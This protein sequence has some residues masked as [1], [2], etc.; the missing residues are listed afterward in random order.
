M[1]NIYLLI[2][3][4]ALSYADVNAQ[5]NRRKR[6]TVLYQHEI[7]GN[8]GFS[9][10]QADFEPN[11][12]ANGLI[13]I[14][15]L[16]IN[17][18]HSVHLLPRRYDSSIFV[19]RLILKSNFGYSYGSFNN[20]G[21][22]TGKELL[23]TTNTAGEKD[24]S[25]TPNN[26]L[27]ARLTSKTSIITFGTQLEFYFRDIT[28]YLHRFNKYRQRNK[29]NPYIALGFGANYVNSTPS[30]DQEALTNNAGSSSAKSGGFPDNYILG[31]TVKG[32]K[33]LVLSATAAIGTRYKLSR[34]V[35]LVTEMKI[36]YYLSDRIDAV[37]PDLKD[38]N[39]FSSQGVDGDKF[40]DYNTVIS[41]GIIYH[42]F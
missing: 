37:N 14:N 2:V 24:Y 10:F 31:E 12:P 5:W 25:K 6:K 17:A 16:S 29:M 18:T 1:K 15:G 20:Y 7:G 23:Y 8:I 21:V 3:I 41:V 26:I 32:I 9:N 30:Y 38:S 22:G 36:N 34:E 27:L 13:T 42:L 4:L 19:K 11:G 39:S 35:D 40:N 33:G 28:S